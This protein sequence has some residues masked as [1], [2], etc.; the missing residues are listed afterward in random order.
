MANQPDIVMVDKQ[1]KK[2]VAIPSDSN[3][4]KKDLKKCRGLGEGLENM[5][6][7]KTTVVPMIIGALRGVTPKLGK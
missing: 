4:M 3:I 6:K 5:W 2:A 7:L 1:R